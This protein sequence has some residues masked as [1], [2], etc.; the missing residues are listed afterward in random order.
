[1]PRVAIVIPAS[2]NPAFLSQIAAMHR[3]L[4]TLGWT[5]W[6]P[7]VHVMFGGP[8]DAAA[9]EQW[10]PHLGRATMT[11]LAPLDFA[12]K[13]IW[14]Q[15]DAELTAAPRDA[16]VVL[17]MDAD[18][19][20][21]RNIE[22]VLDQVL[23]EKAIAGCM[24]HYRMPVWNDQPEREVWASLADGLTDAPLDFVHRYSM[25]P[26]AEPA[27]F[28]L[29][30]GAVFVESGALQG[31]LRHFVPFRTALAERL[32]KPVFSAQVALTLAAAEAGVKQIVLPER[33][34]F[35][36][37]PLSA[38]L[39]PDE[40]REAAV[41]HYLRPKDFDRAK[42][43]A[44]A[45]AYDAFM[46]S[47]LAG[48]N[49]AF[50]D[51]VR[52]V[53][54]PRYPF[55]APVA[56]EALPAA[57][58]ARISALDVEIQSSPTAQANELR[59]MRDVLATG[60]F[61]SNHYVA[62]NPQLV[63]AREDPLRHYVTIGEAAGQRPN[64]WFDPAFYRKHCPDAT[65]AANML[66]HYAQSGEAAGAEASAEFSA[67]EYRAANPGIPGLS[68]APLRHWM[69]KGQAEGLQHRLPGSQSYRRWRRTN[70]RALDS[71]M[72]F[73]Q[74][75]VAEL[76]VERGF[77][78]YREMLGLPDG[79]R[80]VRRPLVA[81][82]D[83]ARSRGA[84][85]RLIT[86]GGTPFRLDAPEVVGPGPL[87]PIDGCCRSLYL[88]CLPAAQVRGASSVVVQGDAALLDAEGPEFTCMDV[89][90][91]FD[92]AVFHADAETG[93]LWTI[94]GDRTETRNLEEAFCLLG[95]R[96]IAFGH[97]M[98]EQL[99]KY[100]QAR[101]AGL[102][103]AVPVLIETGLPPAHRKSLETL[104]PGIRLIEL[105][106][107]ETLQVD[108]LWVA[109]T[110]HFAPLF[111]RRTE[112]FS[113]SHWAA[114]VSHAVAPLADLGARAERLAADVPQEARI[115]LARRPGTHRL[116]VN[117]LAIEAMMTARGYHVVYPET[118]SFV[119]Q[120]R[121][122][123]SARTV[124]AADGS[125]SFLMLLA[126]PGTQLCLLSS[127]YTEP[128]GFFRGLLKAVGT[129][130]IIVSGPIV[131]P[132]PAWPEWADYETDPA[133]LAAVLDRLEQAPAEQRPTPSDGARDA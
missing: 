38:R 92:A 29:N 10:R 56:A 123:R 55:D 54:G 82:V 101:L 79:A 44:S 126:R 18:T 74:A 75:L 20:I 58:Q 52:A 100:A 34:N 90:Y 97:W 13:G 5:R 89:D 19:I 27:P 26:D 49:L 107:F 7:S 39:Y 25:N 33:Y 95:A 59:L 47:D 94:E 60:L 32:P 129:D 28:Y 50:R 3:A 114:P 12:A 66:L 127:E 69:T 16:D 21:V 113:W 118:L 111:E 64:P 22:T 11:F 35:P 117:H 104:Y 98:W 103:P 85:F 120:V 67:R 72:E 23:I 115:Y 121:L 61:D 78:A 76:G 9:L 6:E 63:E 62:H 125:A 30:F 86:P 31:I 36:N 8:M 77:A 2:C 102:D 4:F 106:P 73:R 42:V 133:A 122:I 96:S 119:D 80:V 45:A 53:L 68:A 65:Q 110:L 81:Q 132:H 91:A 131:K 24:A 57:V 88:A 105:S 40:L 37:D 51:A 112:K 15:A 99:P 93:H 1:M 71:L 46:A 128:H 130:M 83:A 84:P 48:V 124:A 17:A 43:F 14:A 87:G 70:V 116:L 108:R 109:P 41:F